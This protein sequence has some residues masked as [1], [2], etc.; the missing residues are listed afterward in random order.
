MPEAKRKK[1][2][3]DLTGR[4]RAVYSELNGEMTPV[5]HF[6][7][8]EIEYM[9]NKFRIFVH[10]VLQHSGTYTIDERVK[11]A[12]ITYVY[13]KS[14]F[15][16]VGKP[17]VGIVQLTGDTFKD[18]L[19]AIGTKA[20]GAFNTSRDSDLVLT[21]H[22]RAGAEGGSGLQVSVKRNVSEW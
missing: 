11:P 18:C 21:V 5:A 4:W 2:S 8:I 15:Y 14:T 12:Q 20:P 17:R 19:G 10:G 13:D 6:S 1:G 16:D 22:Q 7:G 9:K 3:I